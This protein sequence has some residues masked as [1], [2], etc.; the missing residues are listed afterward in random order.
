MFRLM[1]KCADHFVQHIDK[2]TNK[3]E[4][5]EC[6]ELI[7]K[8]SI[9]VI[10]NCI[11]GI[12][13]NAFS[14][15]DNEFRKMGR[16]ILSKSWKDF[17]R[18]RIRQTM[19]WLYELFNYILSRSELNTFFTRIVMDTMNYREMNNVIRNDFIDLLNELKK[20]PDK[21]GDISK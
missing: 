1:S 14:D 11:F 21:L 9:D 4:A 3:N 17:L 18:I 6:Y 12:E 16:L 8:Y 13:M 20:H 19:P 15:E 5:I 10:G 2:I 7:S